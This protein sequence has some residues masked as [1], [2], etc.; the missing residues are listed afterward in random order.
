[1]VYTRALRVYVYPG[2]YFPGQRS[3]GRRQ[4]QRSAGHGHVRRGRARRCGGPGGWGFGV[5]R[6]GYRV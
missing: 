1:M 2:P 6:L 4:V 3:G 5:W